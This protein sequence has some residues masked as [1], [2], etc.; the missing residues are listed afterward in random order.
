MEEIAEQHLNLQWKRQRVDQVN[1]LQD[2]NTL[3]QM[4]DNAPY[5]NRFTTHFNMPKIMNLPQVLQSTQPSTVDAESPEHTLDQQNQPADRSLT[6][7]LFRE[8]LD[9]LF[10][11][12]Q[13]LDHYLRPAPVTHT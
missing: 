6:L 11:I 10:Q 3:R 4:I 2:E 7:T 12:E 5:Q 1:L 9:S 8:S 13:P